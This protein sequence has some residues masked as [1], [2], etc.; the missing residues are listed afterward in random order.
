MAIAAQEEACTEGRALAERPKG[1]SVWVGLRR[2][3]SPKMREVVPKRRDRSA[4]ADG[5]RIVE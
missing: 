4:G 2:A 1:V 5:E 3:E